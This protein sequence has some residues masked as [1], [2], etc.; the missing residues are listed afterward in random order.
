[1][2]T[3]EQV[4]Q[5]QPVAEMA[6]NLFKTLAESPSV[7]SLLQHPGWEKYQTYLTGLLNFYNVAVLYGKKE[8]RDEMIGKA[9]N[10]NELIQLPGSI[11]QHLD[12]ISKGVK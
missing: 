5:T 6:N 3:P 10:L 7:Q 9:K 2:A 4:T 8:D 12:K 11:K 1:M